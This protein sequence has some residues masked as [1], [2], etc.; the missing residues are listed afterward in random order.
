MK[1]EEWDEWLDGFEKALYDAA[2]RVRKARVES[3]P[4]CTGCKHKLRTYA[5][6]RCKVCEPTGTMFEAGEEGDGDE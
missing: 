3:S 5:S 4:I 6:P 2:S 1:M